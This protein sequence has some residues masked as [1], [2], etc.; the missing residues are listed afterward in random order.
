MWASLIIF[1]ISWTHL[2]ADG[3][4]SA[5]NSTRIVTFN[6]KSPKSTT[7]PNSNYATLPSSY[8]S[9]IRPGE[10]SA[11][12][13]SVLKSL[14]L[15]LNGSSIYN[16]DAS[17]YFACRDGRCVSLSYLCDGRPDCEEGEDELLNNCPESSP[18]R[19]NLPDC[20]SL[21]YCV[22]STYCTDQTCDQIF[23]CPLHDDEV[24]CAVDV[25]IDS[26]RCTEGYCLPSKLQHCDGKKDCI[27]GSD[28][29]GCNETGYK[30]CHEF[31]N[32]YQCHASAKCIDV[33][34]LC[35]NNT[36]CPYGDDES[37]RCAAPECETFGCKHDCQQ[38]PTGPRCLCQPGYKLAFGDK[39]CEDIDECALPQP[40][41]SHT[42]VNR[43]GSYVCH[44]REGYRL[45]EKGTCVAEN[46]EALIVFA[47]SS[48]IRGYYLTS[49]RYFEIGKSPEYGNCTV[50]GIDMDSSERSVY[51]VEICDGAGHVHAKSVAFNG[52]ER[53]IV[54]DG[55]KA[56]L[57]VAVDSV[58]N[59]IYIADNGLKQIIVCQKQGN[60][61]AVLIRNGIEK[62]LSIV[63]YHEK[64]LMFWSDWG[65]EAN[66]YQAFMDGS[67]VEM[68]IKNDTIHATG[69]TIDRVQDRLY[70]ADFKVN[71]IE[72]WD[73]QTSKRVSLY[74][75]HN[76]GPERLGIFE[77]QVYFT[78]NRGRTIDFINKIAATNRTRLLSS[79]KI[80]AFR[81]F[82]PVLSPKR[83][84]PC[85]D[86]PCSHICTLKGTEYACV[87][88]GHLELDIN[89]HDCIP[90]SKDP[91]ILVSADNLIS[92]V[93]FESVGRN[94][95]IPVWSSDAMLGCITFDWS[96]STIFVFHYGSSEIVAVNLTE[97]HFDKFV[98][99]VFVLSNQTIHGL[100]YDSF[101]NNLYW[102][103]PNNGLLEIGNSN[104][105]SR[106]TLLSNL[107]RPTD[108]ALY[109]ES[110]KIYI[111][112]LGSDPHIIET[113]LD[114]SRPVKFLSLVGS[115]PTSIFL[116]KRRKRLYW[117][118]ALHGVVEKIDI[119][120]DESS[121]STVLS[122]SGQV[123]S[124]IVHNDTLYWTTM[125]SG[126]M[127]LTKIGSTV[128]EASRIDLRVPDNSPIT[129]YILYAKDE[130]LVSQCLRD[131]G[132]CSHICVS[133]EGKVK[134]LCPPKHKLIDGYTCELER[135]CAPSL[136]SC[137]NDRTCL[138]PELRCDHRIDCQDGTDEIGCG[139]ACPDA[140]FRCMEGHCIPRAWHCDGVG[141][142]K[143]HSDEVNCTLDRC[144]ENAFHCPEGKCIEKKW[145][146]DD[147]NDCSD[148]S[149]E[150]NCSSKVCASS[151]FQCSDA[152]CIP[153]NWRCDG[154]TDCSDG[155]DEVDCPKVQ[156]GAGQF[157][158][159]SGT[160]VDAKMECDRLFDCGDHSDEH[161]DCI[162]SSV[163]CPPDLYG[164]SD[165]HCIYPNEKCD[166][167][168]DCINQED[169]ENCPERVDCPPDQ[170]RCG[171]PNVSVSCIPRK[172]LCDNANDCGDW[173]DETSPQC[174]AP[175]P[176][177]T[178]GKPCRDGSFPC[179]SGDC[180]DYSQ[181]CDQI[182]HCLDQSD[183]GG[184]CNVACHYSN[185]NCS[186]ICHPSPSGGK[187]DCP[188]GF[189][190]DTDGK[191]CLDLDECAQVGFCSQF[192]ENYPG[193][194]KCT[195]AEGYYPVSEGHKCKA[196]GTEASLL[197]MLPN[198][199][200][201]ISLHTQT[202][203]SIVRIRPLTMKGMDYDYLNRTVYWIDGE[204]GTINGIHYAGG[205]ADFEIISNL[206]RP[207]HLSWDYIGQNFY[208]VE[209]DSK[210]SV[211]NVNSKQCGLV[212]STELSKIDSFVVSPQNRV[213][214]W[215]S[216]SASH[217]T[218]D[219]RIERCEMDGRKR[220]KIIAFN[221]NSPSGL[222]VDP[223]MKMI[224]WVDTKQE[225]LY[226]ANFKGKNIHRLL[227]YSLL[228]PLSIGVFEDYIYWANTGAD[229]L[230]KCNKFTGKARVIVH[231]GNIKAHA[232]KIFHEVLQQPEPNPCEN[233][234]C[235]HICVLSVK[236][237]TCICP[238]HFKLSKDNQTCQIER[239]QPQISAFNK[240]CDSNPCLNGATC[241][242]IHI[243]DWEC[244][245]PP[246]FF[247]RT[248]ETRAS[249]IN[250]PPSSHNW[251]IILII[252]VIVLFL[253]IIIYRT[254]RSQRLKFLSSYFRPLRSS[255]ILKRF[256][257]D[258]KVAVS[259]KN[260]AFNSNLK[261]DYKDVAMESEAC[262]A[263]LPS[264]KSTSTTG[265]GFSNPLYGQ[266]MDDN[267]Q[268][269]FIKV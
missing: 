100:T 41:C 32:H 240:A 235:S 27:D 205:Q 111:A 246:D 5:S 12:H 226:S 227:D 217:S 175:N 243:V 73:F 229:N 50:K 180:I 258:K 9:N 196:N 262:E 20:G 19:F 13:D 209:S 114:G 7:K 254:E 123:M 10:T 76:L 52:D 90:K 14:N 156:C 202:E 101:T 184:L 188:P 45:A 159:N 269:V 197:Y 124:I 22:N 93:Y 108:M 221:L 201:S 191:T 176:E 83:D 88:P 171:S 220:T 16:C 86:N 236:N 28:E 138:I 203:H 211:C 161:S 174:T 187:C 256:S 56:P 239:S 55:L 81:L 62:I 38:T 71:R 42:C 122:K 162:Y 234:N 87:C 92:R 151:N 78:S 242:P 144:D 104:G 266:Y 261:S 244:E 199:I 204:A 137:D 192:C 65:R 245:C 142:C 43:P 141:D 259:F 120:G 218:T 91:F 49:R 94:V 40:P 64:G 153:I 198:A 115:L 129:K 53:D 18:K 219:G 237:Y 69:L 190:L 118:D 4:I 163:T 136:F 60:P 154:E 61:C 173:W 265:R 186:H 232:M 80:S 84:N 132:G 15:P 125:Q 79:Q 213:M 116:C 238:P 33:K 182:P 268:R 267:D 200:K 168:N 251:I 150:K 8:E 260:P 105:H 224:Y 185:G 23:D 247:G 59:N 126:S 77:D 233:A 106:T 39:K 63:L 249:D 143:D 172:W 48:Q 231:R 2:D 30:P 51:F 110:N 75:A 135:H 155:G 25:C 195:C 24:G 250:L 58:A 98:K 230:M 134:C 264:E 152:K 170:V 44:C 158:C 31:A 21:H 82:H 3:S 160:C 215:S 139:P 54:M 34:A 130:K 207:S 223:V 67:S 145:V 167:Y 194:A 47:E 148:G 46:H 178:T 128:R 146:C 107:E 179:K 37:P 6:P 109:Q 121:R 257:G 85:W 26:F 131:N 140:D 35:D 165:G 169:E 166:G 241:I 149:D 17:L 228:K 113:G 253:V 133:V 97:P 164:C 147:L 193:G 183:E 11:H 68:L 222:T 112:N 99:K 216:W 66:I 157:K 206:E 181:V 117:S 263:M 208:F 89:G 127:W 252:L 248:C 225:E 177:T 36:D 189:Y 96:S 102:L 103:D 1:L 57:D 214:F 74:H 72:Y 119:H 212:I 210:I 70:W 95:L 29:I 255:S